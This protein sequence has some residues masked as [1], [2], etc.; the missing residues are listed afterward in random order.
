MFNFLC[1]HSC[2]FCDELTSRKLDLC[3]GCEKDL[4]FFKNYCKKCASP[5][6]ENQTICG[7]CLN[8][9]KLDIEITVLFRY[10]SM[11]QY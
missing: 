5:L 8:N 4:P 10:E 11:P 9:S 7:F 6:P 3:I 1:R 2:I